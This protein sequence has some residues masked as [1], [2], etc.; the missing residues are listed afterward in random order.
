MVTH[1]RVFEKFNRIEISGTGEHVFDFLGTRT[2]SAFKNGWEKFTIREGAKYKANLPPVNEHYFDWIA[3][4]DSTSRANET[5]RVAELGAGWAPWLVRGA[6]AGMQMP[7]VKN[8]ELLGVEAD[9]THYQWMVD[10]FADNRIDASRHRLLHGAVNADGGTVK[11]PRVLEPDRN[12]GASLSAARNDASDTVEVNGYRLNDIFSFFSGPIDFVHIDIQGA[13]YEVVPDAIDLFCSRVKAL[14]VGTHES[15]E[16][17]DEL[18]N[19]LKSRNWTSIMEYPR[20]SEV[21]TD[22]GPVKFDDGFLYFRNK[23]F[24]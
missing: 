22:F 8:I 20:R 11:F 9:P 6:F 12:Y 10:H 7:N 2:R 23:A 13:E 3:L 4:L 24:S 15:D 19:L 14:M 18:V 21:E 1:H 17:H 16:L 5:L